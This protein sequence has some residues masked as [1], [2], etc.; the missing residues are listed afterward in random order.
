MDIVKRL[1][2]LSKEMP[3][4][5][6]IVEAKKEIIFLRETLTS[7]LQFQ[8]EER[9]RLTKILEL[10]EHSKNILVEVNT[11]NSKTSCENSR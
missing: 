3:Q 1:E 7:T 10:L 9:N 8:I 11:N 4:L 2:Q 6:E 5:L